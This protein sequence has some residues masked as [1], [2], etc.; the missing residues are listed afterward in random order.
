MSRGIGCWKLARC[1]TGFE[2]HMKLQNL[3]EVGH[4]MTRI[5]VYGFRVLC[6]S[7]KTV[8]YE[9]LNDI[10]RLVDGVSAIFSTLLPGKANVLEGV[11]GCELRPTLMLIWQ[12]ESVNPDSTLMHPT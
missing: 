5:F 2:V 12:F 9:P 10:V 6:R 8:A 1:L 7:V 11:H 3:W 4:Y